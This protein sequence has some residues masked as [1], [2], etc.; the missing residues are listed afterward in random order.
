MRKR[1]NANTSGSIGTTKKCA[2]SVGPWKI[3]SLSREP[4]SIGLFIAVIFRT[5]NGQLVK[6]RR[7]ALINHGATD[8]RTGKQSQ[9]STTSDGRKKKWIFFVICGKRKCDNEKSNAKFVQQ[10]FPDGEKC[11]KNSH[12]QQSRNEHGGKFSVKSS[13]RVVFQFKYF[14]F[15]D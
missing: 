13:I 4:I 11:Y 10:R 2:Y 12:K 15:P 1:A 9:L 7:I 14:H 5:W 8:G 6:K 3:E